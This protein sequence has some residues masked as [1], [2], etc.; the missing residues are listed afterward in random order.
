MT[1]LPISVHFGLPDG[2]EPVATDEAA[3]A[4]IRSDTAGIMLTGGVWPL[5]VPLRTV[6]AEAVDDLRE[7]VAEVTVLSGDD[8]GADGFVQE[9]RFTTGDETFVRSEVYLAM[10]EGAEQRA[11]VRA[12]LTCTPGEF[13]TLA[14]DFREFVGSLGPDD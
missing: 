4:A 14:D 10:G 3:F 7:T 5:S 2:W 12:V 8:I 9:L 11:V 13:G 1:P 6:A